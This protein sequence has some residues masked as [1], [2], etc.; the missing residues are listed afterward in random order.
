[1]KLWGLKC[2]KME[3]CIQVSQELDEV[4]RVIAIL[5]A[6]KLRQGKFLL[7][8]MS[9]NPMPGHERISPPLLLLI[10]RWKEHQPQ[11]A[12]ST[13][14]TLKG[15]PAPSRCQPCGRTR[16]KPAFLGSGVWGGESVESAPHR[17]PGTGQAQESGSM[18]ASQSPMKSLA[19]FQT[20]KK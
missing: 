17:G 9:T 13:E 20:L 2:H 7:V 16:T 14:D 11:N 10:P 15:S 3:W 1:M 18:E 8:S 5:Q 6:R 12:T 4:G 19:A